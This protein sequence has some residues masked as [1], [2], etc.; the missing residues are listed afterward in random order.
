MKDKDDIMEDKFFKVRLIL[1][2]SLGERSDSRKREEKW[3]VKKDECGLMAAASQ[4]DV[5]LVQQT[6]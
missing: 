2:L 5:L 3:D 1:V 6:T 4:A